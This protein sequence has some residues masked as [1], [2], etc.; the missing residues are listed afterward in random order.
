VKAKNY[1]VKAF[2]KFAKAIKKIA[3]LFFFGRSGRKVAV[4]LPP[5]FF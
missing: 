2:F 1:F 4:L 5:V 3:R